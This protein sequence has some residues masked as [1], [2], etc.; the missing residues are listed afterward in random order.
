MILDK[1]Y[2]GDGYAGRVE[3][4]E[5]GFAVRYEDLFAGID[6]DE[7]SK[8]DGR[9]V[10]DVLDM[11]LMFENSPAHGLPA[12]KAASPNRF[13]GFDGNHETSL[14]AQADFFFGRGQWSMLKRF[15]GLNS[16]MPMR[17]TYAKMIA[18]WRQVMKPGVD[19]TGDQMLDIIAAGNVP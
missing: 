7:V 15:A 11:F 17:E 9:F 14:V 12:V 5:R 8:V 13:M 19:L 6:D 1:L 3:I 18:R 16:H 10:M 2:P 4:L